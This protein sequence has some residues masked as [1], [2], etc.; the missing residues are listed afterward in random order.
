MAA[1]QRIPVR[2]SKVKPASSKKIVTLNI[3]TQLK[4][5]L[6]FKHIVRNYFLKNS[7]Y[8]I[9]IFLSA[10]IA[11][12]V[13]A[14]STISGTVTDKRHHPVSNA[15]I[16]I[17]N[18]LNGTTTDSAGYFLLSAG[19][20]GT[21][22]LIVSSVGFKDIEKT[23]PL[24]DT[25]IE[26]NFVLQYEDKALDPVVVSVGSFE[27][28]DKAK[29]ASLTPMDAVTVAGNGGD[30]ANAL[31]SLPGSQQV[32]DREG[33]FVRGGTSDEAKQFVDGTL[34]K[35]PNYGSV[36]GIPQ[37]ARLNPFLF[38][39]ILF[40][41]GGYSALYGEALSSAL[42]LES[43]DLPDKSSA[44]L[45]I[46]PMHV[47]AGFQSLAA[48]N[49]SS[50]GVNVN[51]G[52]YVLYNKIV[53]QKPD[54]FHAPEYLET[55]ANFRIKTSKTGILKFYTNYGYNHTGMRNPD[56]DSSDLFS[57]FKT[58]GANVYANL[59]Y[60]ESV[61]NK[62]KVDAALAYNYNKNN[63]VN[64]L[65]DASGQRVFIADV[66]YNEK[67]NSS[68][69]VSNFAQARVV[70]TKMHIR[71]QALRFGAEHFYSDDDYR[72]N[73][74]L[75]NLRDNLTAMFVE[76]DLHVAKNVAAKIGVRAEYSS[77][78][79]HVNIAPRISFAYRLNSGGQFNLAYGI[80]YQKPEIEFLAKSNHITFTQATHYIINY[81]KKANN[82]L[83]RIEA[84]YKKYKDL[85][86][87]EPAVSNDGAGY[88]RG[89]EL[90]FRDKKTIKNFDYWI[91]YTYLDTK[92]KYL[93]YPYELQPDYATPHTAS[94]AVKRFFPNINF[95][96]NMLY[97]LATGRPYYNIQPG[98]NGKSEI[99][100]QGT[101]NMYNQMNL[102]FAYLFTMFKN[103][104][105]KDF[106]G[107]GFGMNNVFGTRQ[108]FGYNY[109][110][111][112]LYKMPVTQP[113][114]RSYYIGLFMS[115]GIDRRDDFIN[116]KL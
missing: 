33:L 16:S 5:Y 61:G 71:N 82:R 91:T 54:F 65:E 57:T 75:T 64:E 36:P 13:S 108:I 66:P 1:I 53:K 24:N 29:G 116:E 111:N 63:I 8:Y 15:S 49:K 19:V 67:N 38:K 88:A 6:L 74:T 26:I 103:W 41:T 77:L 44:S 28:S 51:Y 105:N 21:Q 70:L 93:Y 72:Y 107:I 32:G 115:F 86:T 68:G 100:N 9:I 18:S 43:V 80:F 90:F 104:K 98:V 35:N 2:K 92:R 81:Q 42:I 40:N 58:K 113:A 73:D 50:Y 96:A 3:V 56:V 22:T 60:R 110:Y 101:T 69:I 94:I 97:V 114:S 78:L 79:D 87:K 31:R 102:S 76:G 37:P 45:H 95:S 85:V 34:L 109:S 30:I 17:K 12:H 25:I 52:S 46:F 106:S 14:Q 39:G 84:Y 23:I 59:S 99:L 11:N 112:G 27:A 20:Q 47:G 48:N 4:L 10:L 89:V 83:F 62:W 55:D 7:K